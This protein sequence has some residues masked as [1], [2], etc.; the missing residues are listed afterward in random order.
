MLSPDASFVALPKE[1]EPLP[2][3][4][5]RLLGS[6]LSPTL[7]TVPISDSISSEFIGGEPTAWRTGL[8][9][10][11][12]VYYR[13]VYPGI[14]VVYYSRDGRIA[15]DF[16]VEPGVDPA[17]IEI[18]F[19]SASPQILPPP[20]EIAENGVLRVGTGA[21][22]LELQKP[23]VYQVANQQETVIPS[24]FVLQPRSIMNGGGD[25]VSVAF[26]LGDYDLSQPLVIDPV[27][28]YSTRLGGLTGL[29]RGRDIAVDADG[30]VYV[31]GETFGD[32]FS[33]TSQVISDVGGSVDVFVTKIDP[34]TDDIIY[35]TRLGGSGIDKGLAI[36]LDDEG[37]V[38]VTGSTS[39][40][41]FP[42]HNA[43]QSHFSGG[44]GAFG[45]AFVFV[46]GTDGSEMIYSTYL[47]G[48]GDDLASDIALD[49]NGVIYVTGETRSK[50]FPAKLS[51]QDVFGGGLA[52]GFLA[53]ID[54][55]ESSLVFSTFLG[56]TGD[57]V[58]TSVALDAM[59]FSYVTG[60]TDSLN[61]LTFRP[62]QGH[63]G[64]GSS[65]AFVT[66]VS[67]KGEVVYSSY[68]GGKGTDI[69]SGIFVDDAGHAHVA[70]KTFSDD[71]PVMGN[72][73]QPFFAGRGDGF[74]SKVSPVGDKLLYSTYLGGAGLDEINDIAVDADQQAHVI[75]TTSSLDYF[76][77][78]PL[79]DEFGGGRDAFI[80]KLGPN[81]AKLKFSTYLG[82]EREEV[83]SAITLDGL[84]NTYITGM[85]RSA[86]FP[87]VGTFRNLL[88]QASAGAAFIGKIGVGDLVV[89]D[90]PDL[91]V[92]VEQIKFDV[93]P[94]GDRIVVKFV[95]QNVGTLEAS[96]PFDVVL[97]R[98]I[99]R[100]L[101]DDD[102]VLQT[103]TIDSLKAGLEVRKRFKV[104]GLEPLDGQ[105]VIVHVDDGNVVDEISELNNTVLRA[106]SPSR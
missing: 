101:D 2:M 63:N 99:N 50:N 69:G 3:W 27:L 11:A 103:F 33:V 57:D 76:E 81:G 49:E 14:D 39:S 91:S 94:L 100:R 62:W 16:L 67:P 45:D 35:S 54:P 52:D 59:G 105:F 65:D 75:G 84:G 1:I 24:A 77:V 31:V 5:M 89:K 44:S 7:E 25:D 60:Y 55:D 93:K 28:S 66:K 104:T 32:V 26:D 79:Q 92:R 23:F 9:N 42:V 20:L 73:V 102:D 13:E 82:A 51:L 37:R 12:R 87:T 95:V 46:L 38:Y 86:N 71:F 34:R 17:A 106:F 19:E 83:G 40:H 15:F 58:A 47:G 48:D 56:G 97:L 74:I 98:S 53:S 78:R 64:G 85:L 21:A 36:T 8:Q 10:Y 41:D 6:N 22:L 4:R 68:L 30:M 72:V 43:V 90:L 29:T 96:R 61:F 80:T 18:V 70:G 88:G